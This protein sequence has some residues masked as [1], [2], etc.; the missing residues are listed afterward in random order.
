M[1]C[2]ACEEHVNTELSKLKGVLNYSTS[3]AHKNSII[4]FDKSVVDISKIE[5][6][7]NNT[8]YNAV[9]YKILNLSK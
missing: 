6:A 5:A 4:T 7:I 9:D 2:E 3:Y 8:G 1:S